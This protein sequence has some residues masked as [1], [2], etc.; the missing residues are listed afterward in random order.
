MRH[1]N[2]MIH[3]FQ[4]T[5][6]GAPQLTGQAGSIIAI[7]NACLLNGFNLRTLTGITR[8]G[9]V[10]TVIADAGH[11]FKNGDVVHIAGANQSAYNGRMR[12]RD[13]TTNSFKFDVAGDPQT[14]ATGTITAKI[15]SLDWEGVYS[16]TNKA[17]YRSKDPSTSRLFLR[18]DETPLAGDINYGR[19]TLS[20]IVQLWETLA[21]IDNGTG[22]SEVLWRKSSRQDAVVRPW[23]LIGDQKRF[24]LCVAWNE[25]YP[26][27]YVP[28]VLGDFAS[29]KA[30]DPYSCVLG[31]YA[32]LGYTWHDPATNQWLD[33]VGGVGAAIGVSGIVIPRDYSLLGGTTTVGWVSG[34]GG[35]SFIGMGATNLVYPNPADNGIF[36]MPLLI[37]EK[38][39]PSLRG[40]VPGLLAPLHSITAIEPTRLPG[41]LLDSS[42]RDL[43]IVPACT[44]N[45]AAKLAFDLTGPWD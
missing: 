21:D 14:P 36:V 32:E 42:L 35:Q 37:Q 20:C 11:G 1:G 40:R 3:Y 26:S 19:G 15:A 16:A 39:G 8:D 22:K 7:L 45:G 6:P 2:P 29:F 10:A 17:V 5:Q 9:A 23:I 30:G 38:T 31:G 13:V 12:I 24:W 34:V 4:H 25:N 33:D 43:L 41:F 27:R 44:A 28:Y 18:V